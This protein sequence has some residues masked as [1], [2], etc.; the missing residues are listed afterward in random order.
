MGA[1]RWPDGGIVVLVVLVLVT[2]TLFFVYVIQELGDGVC[3][4]VGVGAMQMAWFGIF[5]ITRR[6]TDMRVLIYEIQEVSELL[7]VQ[8]ELDSGMTVLVSGA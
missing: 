6:A 3:H 5:G 4:D 8:W 1:R 7:P 2:D